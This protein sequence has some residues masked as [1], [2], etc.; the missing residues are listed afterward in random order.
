MMEILLAGEMWNIEFMETDK[1]TEYYENDTG[2]KS[3]KLFGFCD[4]YHDTIV[5]DINLCRNEIL[6][7][8]RHELT[9]A[10]VHIL[11]HNYTGKYNEEQLCNLVAVFSP[12]VEKVVKDF[13]ANDEVKKVLKNRH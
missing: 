8:L 10:L 1:I 2:F 4:F 5:I 11:G 13:L 3:V 7:T 9:H 6:N 12:I